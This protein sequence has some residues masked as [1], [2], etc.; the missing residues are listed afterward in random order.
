MEIL[1]LILLLVLV[2][3]LACINGKYDKDKFDS[4]ESDKFDR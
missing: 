3:V 1:I 4:N 2:V